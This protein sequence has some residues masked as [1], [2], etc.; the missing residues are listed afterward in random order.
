M[1]ISSLVEAISI[2]PIVQ[3]R[4]RPYSSATFSRTRSVKLSEAS[5]TSAAARRKMTLK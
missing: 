5:S 2:R 1:L 4:I 3:N